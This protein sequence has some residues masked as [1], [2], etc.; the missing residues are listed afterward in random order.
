MVDVIYTD[1]AEAILDA[2]PGPDVKDVPDAEKPSVLTVPEMPSL[3]A[4]TA[5]ASFIIPFRRTIKAGSKGRDVVG[6]KRALW[7]ANGLPAPKGATQTFGAIAVKQLREFQHAHGLKADGQLGA[8]TLKKLAPYFDQF[9]FLLYVGYAPGNA[10]V[11]KQNRFLAYQLWGYNH[12][13]LIH[14]AQQRPM[15]L[16]NDLQH[17]PV[18]DDC[19]EFFTK[20]AKY[21]GF[22]DPNGTGFNG[23]GYTGTLATH[24]KLVTLA[25][26]E[27]GAAVLYGPAPTFEHVAGY[28]GGGRVISH[29]SEGG[30][31]LLPADYRTIAQ[32]RAYI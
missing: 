28:I 17:L 24:G 20:A 12:R 29:G 14:Y 1:I 10:K 26:A 30:P 3:V 25:N 7:K 19:S 27:V 4:R 22:P 9:A 23:S 32:I 11:A 8:T 21:A 2:P 18:W 16:L 15:D 5:P 31:F 6:A 13:G